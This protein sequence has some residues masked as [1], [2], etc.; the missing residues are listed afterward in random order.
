MK[1]SLFA[2][3]LIACVWLKVG[4]VTFADDAWQAGVAATVITPQTS[5]WMSGYASRTKPSEGTIH[6]LWAKA[7]VLQD[8]QGHKALLIT[9]DLVGIDRATSQAICERLS[10]T[11]GLKRAA[12][13]LSTSHTHSGP[14]VGK[15]LLTMYALDEENHQKIVEYTAF[16]E[17]SVA[18]VTADAFASLAPAIVQHGS[19]Q[20]EFAVNRRNNREPDVPMLRE[21]GQLVGPVDHDVPVLVVK[22]P[23]GQLRAIL[24]EYACHATVLSGMNWCGDWPGFAQLEIERRHPGAIAMF[25][26]GCGADQNPLPRRTV[27][28]A[29][30]YGAQI[31]NSVDRTLAGQLATVSGK[32]STAYREID[33]ALDTLPT[34]EQ[35]ES[36]LKSDNVY[37]ARRAA[38]LLKQLAG[39]GHLSQT[40]PYPVQLWRLG[41]EL[42]IT[43]LGGEVVVDFA[44]RLKSELP[45]KSNW[46]GGYCND[47]MAYIPSARVLKEG[48]YE[49]ETAM[50]YYGLPAKWSPDVEEHIVR[51]VKELAEASAKS[52]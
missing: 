46:I 48:G 31:A 44:V 13:A 33:L 28:L 16:L 34:R 7:L 49:G 32:L 37:I 21:A 24:F 50:I 47:V 51:T 27:E 42:Q 14:V 18:K 12:I 41:N 23:A 4:P 38:H 10:K 5:M 29:E 9:L 19:G 3:V 26:A 25:M 52:Q 8:P 11:H 20:A 36:D 2:F 1:R 35:I 40:Y 43:I 45:G 15:N 22:S 39:D 17:E 6:D 30:N